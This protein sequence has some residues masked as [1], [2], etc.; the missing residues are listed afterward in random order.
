MCLKGVCGSMP[1]HVACASQRLIVSKSLC[2]FLV[3]Y[4][5]C[6]C[7]R[8]CVHVCVCVRVYVCVCVCVSVCVC[9]CVCV[10]VSAHPLMYTCTHRPCG[11]WF[12][13]PHFCLLEYLNLATCS[14]ILLSI[15]L[16]N[17]RLTVCLIL[18]LGTKRRAVD[19]FL[20]CQFFFLRLTGSPRI[21]WC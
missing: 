18:G 21:G 1:K 7:A 9:V 20:A 14:S 3:L 12:L 15:L 5:Y 2:A 4:S 10:C 11:T 6:A 19:Y 16:H 13:H 8:V 17:P